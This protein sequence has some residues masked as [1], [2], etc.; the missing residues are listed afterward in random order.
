MIIIMILTCKKNITYYQEKYE[1]FRTTLNDQDNIKFKWLFVTGSEEYNLIDVYDLKTKIITV[2]CDDNYES[3]PYKVYLGLK[4]IIMNYSTEIP[5][6]GIFKIDDTS[7]INN[8]SYVL[9]VLNTNQSLNYFGTI[10]QDNRKSYYYTLRKQRLKKFQFPRKYIGKKF[11]NSYFCHGCGYYLSLHSCK[12]VLQ[13]LDIIKSN[14]LEDTCIG[15]ILNQNGILPEI[16][17]EFNS[18][19]IHK[20]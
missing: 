14:V 2:P 13:N 20:P 5:I 10:A 6:N 9:Q 7:I 8:L 19:L 12:I 16:I 17:P 15:Y 18:S 11:L 3:L 1:L 4:H